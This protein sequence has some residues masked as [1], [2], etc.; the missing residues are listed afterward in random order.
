MAEAKTKYFAGFLSGFGASNLGHI[1][2]TWV[3]QRDANELVKIIEDIDKMGEALFHLNTT[4]KLDEWKQLGKPADIAVG[5]FTDARLC[6]VDDEVVK[7]LEV[8]HKK[9][10]YHE[11]GE[12]PERKDKI[13]LHISA[14]E[15]ASKDRLS[16]IKE[17]VPEKLFI[18]RVGGEYRY[19]KTLYTS[20]VGKL[21]CGHQPDK[22]A[23]KFKKCEWC[24]GTG[25][26]TC[27][28]C[29]GF[30]RLFHYESGLHIMPC[31]CEGGY[32]ERCRMCGG[33][34]AIRTE[35]DCMQCQLLQQVADRG[36][37]KKP[38]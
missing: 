27:S 2:I 10:Y 21:E 29:H 33:D 35:F 1:T 36:D 22:L 20:R 9:W 17:I 11:D 25:G 38:G 13:T 7:L 16:K 23:A 28:A 24:D 18:K 37:S 8:F 6:H 15:K 34:K 14:S 12:A 4:L 30:G 19:I 5:K 26:K 31:G 32:S 3:G